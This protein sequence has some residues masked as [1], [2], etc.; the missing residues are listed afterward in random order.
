M[1]AI[2]DC[3]ARAR[4]IYPAATGRRR[5]RVV[6]ARPGDRGRAPEDGVTRV[7]VV[8]AGS[9]GTAVAAIVAGNVADDVVGARPASSRR[10]STTEHENPDYLPGIRLPDALRATA[11]LADA[12]ADA[13]VVVL[14]VPS[15]GL[16]AVLADA[17]PH[18]AHDAAVV[19]LAKGI[20]QGT[21]A[22]HDRGHRAKCSPTTTPTRIGVLTGPNLAR[23]VAAGQPTASVVAMTDA[24][25]AEELQQ[26]FFAP[27]FR[28]YTNPDVVGC[29]MAGALKNVLAIGAG[30][31]DGLGYGD[32]TKAALMTRG[33][34]ELARLG[35]AMGGEPLTFAGLA[36]MGDLI[37][38]CSSPQSRNRH[39]GVELGRGR[40]LDEIVDEMN[41]VAEGVKT[42]GG[43]HRARG[44]P[45]RGDAARVVRRTR[46]L[47][48]R[49]P[50]RPRSRADA[51]QGEA[52]AARHG[53]AEPARAMTEAVLGVLGAG[54]LATVDERG[55]ISASG[56]ELDWWV[57]ADDR[58]H[59]PAERAEH[60]PPT[61]RAPR[62]CSRRPCA[63]PAGGRAPRLRRR[64]RRTARSWRSTSRTGHRCRS[65]SDSWCASARGRVEVDGY[66]RAR[67]R[68]GRARAL[69]GAA[70]LGNRRPRP[71]EPVMAGEARDGPV[72]PFDGPGELALLF[73]VPHRTAVRAALGVGDGPRDRARALPDA[74]AVARGWDAQLE[75]GLQ[76][77]LPPPVG[78][79]RRRGAR[80]P[81]ARAARCAASS[82]RSRTGA[83]TPKPPPAGRSS[84][85]AL[86]GEPA[87]AS[88]PT[89]RGPGCVR[90]TR[91]VT[92]RA[93]WSTLRAVLVREH[94]GADRRA[95]RLPRPTGSASR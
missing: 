38:T 44:A 94:G 45:R 14:A 55:A 91:R 50:G 57:G 90:S 3:V 4:E 39:V 69:G 29:E 68:L 74:D 37:A 89:I 75:R 24:A 73:P 67:R 15:H 41:M 21:L 47:R 84:D 25:V 64:R 36:G 81:P 32:N 46:A 5:R 42:H 62:R 26:L 51:A 79:R 85:G 13:D 16:R 33:L 92:R 72:E 17:R 52:R 95:A 27:T 58:W 71:R 22:A 11:D 83:S 18:I 61:T 10:R 20:E 1:A 31:A 9:W 54:A 48:G 66:G 65:R 76:A 87:A 93:S 78:E 59:V 12:C 70:P 43:G 63:C 80:R 6:V 30:I 7:A 77:E 82:R 23:E 34:A 8:G 40:A 56:V 88:S 19:S 60:A 28:V 2:V 86:V 53:G 49:A 35:V